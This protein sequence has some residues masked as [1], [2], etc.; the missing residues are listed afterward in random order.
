MPDSGTALLRTL[1]WALL[2]WLQR[3]FQYLVRWS[4]YSESDDLWLPQ[5]ELENC[6]ALTSGRLVRQRKH[7]S[8]FPLGFLM[9]LMLLVDV[10]FL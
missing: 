2:P 8:F 6:E 1:L 5:R 9:H 4:G 10:G 3:G 7:S